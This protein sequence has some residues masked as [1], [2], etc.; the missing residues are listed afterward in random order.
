MCSSFQRRKFP[1]I[2]FEF[3]VQKINTIQ[4]SNKKKKKQY[5]SQRVQFKKREKKEKNAR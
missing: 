4:K 3:V 1:F 2:F 5:S